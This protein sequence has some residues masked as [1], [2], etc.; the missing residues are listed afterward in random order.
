MN[1]PVAVSAGRDRLLRRGMVGAGAAAAIVATLFASGLVPTSGANAQPVV[2]EQAVQ[3]PTFADVVAQVSPA[4]VGVRVQGMTRMIDI[5]GFDDMPGGSPEDRFFFRIPDGNDVVP[6]TSLGSG[7]FVSDDGYIV[8]NNH[9]IDDAQS[10]TVIM[11]DGT[12]YPATLI[13][14]DP[15]TDIAL[16][17]VDADRQF[18]YVRFSET[19]VRVGDWALAVGS[20]YDLAGTVTLGIVSGQE[21][22]I[23]GGAYDQFLQ[24]DAAVN[25]GNSG[26]PTFNLA[27]EVI[28][29][30]TAIFSP[31][32]G[33]IGIA[34]AVPAQVAS[35]VVADLLDDGIVQRGWL[36]V[37]IQSVDERLA[38]L[39][40]LDGPGG[41]I[42]GTAFEGEPAANAGLKSRDVVT[43]LNG[44]AIA[45]STAFARM[46]GNFDPGAEVTLTVVRDGEAIEIN[47]TLGTMP[48]D[49]VVVAQARP[50]EERP[51]VGL[52]LR[53]GTT[54]AGE[55][56]VIGMNPD[57]TAAAAGLREG[58]IILG[59]DDIR[60]EEFDDLAEAVESARAAGNETMLFEIRR[61]D[62]V[63][64]LAV[65]TW[66][67]D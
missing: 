56:V 55:V 46:V 37:Q 8:T 65:D 49:D 63:F 44:N 41:V 57:G 7:F 16:L 23:T 13:G 1:H 4:V 61:R 15:L 52:G 62:S 21:R 30:N 67:N 6:T 11:Y 12:E 60:V 29:V 27:G 64:F 31:S 19:P 14:S 3:L 5:A 53:T 66:V 43:A 33:N 10:F 48:M 42:I 24:I 28:G 38:G 51:E 36:G 58:D 32:G 17:K 34:F 9:V 18:T 50:E 35:E 40:G 2:V 47:V 39:L 22:R 25:R 20:P 59:V 26:G 45:D 54:N